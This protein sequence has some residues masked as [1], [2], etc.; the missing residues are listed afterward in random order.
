[1]YYRSNSNLGCFILILC[2]L[3]ILAVVLNLLLSPVFWLAVGILVLISWIQNAW[4]RR[5]GGADSDVEYR[6]Y[7]NSDSESECT[8]ATNDPNRIEEVYETNA[9]DVDDVEVHR[10]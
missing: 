1:M 3:L 4:R 9:V 8:E 7:T 10:D 6:S 2:V 5:R